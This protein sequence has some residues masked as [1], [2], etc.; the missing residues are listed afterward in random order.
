[1]YT[2]RY[3]TSENMETRIVAAINI[4]DIYS[5]CGISRPCDF[6]AN[7]SKVHF[8][9]FETKF[10]ELTYQLPTSLLLNENMEFEGFGYE[11]EQKYSSLHEN[12]THESY[13]FFRRF[14]MQLR[15]S[16]NTLSD[17]KIYTFD[18]EKHLP[19]IFIF[20]LVIRFFRSRVTSHLSFRFGIKD[21]EIFW[22]LTFPDEWTG[23]YERL[24]H[25]AAHMGGLKFGCF[26]TL[27]ESNAHIDLCKR[28]MVDRIGKKIVIVDCGLRHIFL[29]ETMTEMNHESIGIWDGTFI[30]REIR[31][32]LK[33]VIGSDIYGDDQA[34]HP[35]R[36]HILREVQANIC[37]NSL[38][39]SVKVPLSWQQ[40][41]KIAM[42]DER[43]NHKIYLTGDKLR[44]SKFWICGRFEIA[45]SQYMVTVKRLLDDNIRNEIVIV[46]DLSHIPIVRTFIKPDKF[47]FYSENFKVSQLSA[48][49]GALIF[50]HTPRLISHLDSKYKFLGELSKIDLLST[51]IGNRDNV[52][53]KESVMDRSYDKI[54]VPQDKLQY[55]VKKMNLND[56][57]VHENVIFLK[58]P[59][60]QI[61]LDDKH[62]IADVFSD[63]YNEEWS[64]SFESL[65]KNGLSEKRSVFLL[66]TILEESLRLVY[67]FIKEQLW[68]V[69]AIFDPEF[70]SNDVESSM[71]VPDE[72]R[73]IV[74]QWQ[75]NDY[76]EYIPTVQEYCENKL[77]KMLFLPESRNDSLKNYIKSIVSNVWRMAV[78]EPEM[79]LDWTY[80]ENT[81]IDNSVVQLFNTSGE[82]FDYIVW[83]AI[84]DRKDGNILRRAIVQASKNIQAQKSDDKHFGLVYFYR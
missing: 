84:Y 55:P 42:E 52:C 58:D 5:Q 72:I 64:D 41:I 9:A 83:P 63:I 36:D 28:T 6:D 76:K 22:V 33:A 47:F 45:F 34:K 37:R 21:D 38:P 29:N 35:E 43:Y 50:G 20:S 79:Y 60:S 23:L 32:L 30:D 81:K 78:S 1:M 24:F 27:A 70:N 26:S 15:W 80:Q 71:V 53:E 18:A 11:A 77:S 62:E 56:D 13:Y 65:I 51:T 12:G 54:K 25:E 40:Q 68:Q 66:M 46:G 75:K 16:R 7:P 69:A 74:E 8:L 48:V 19:M 73:N 67:E 44:I 31:A 57:E 82:F 49:E 39:V 14:R 3:R 61:V 4:G 59:L 17:V 2:C 10:N